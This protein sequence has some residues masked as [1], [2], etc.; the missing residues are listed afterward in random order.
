VDSSIEVGMDIAA[1]EPVNILMVDDQPAKL[2][3]YEAILRDLGE[4]LVKASSGREALEHLLKQDFAMI[5]VDVCMPEQDGFALVELIRQHPRF[6]KIPVIFISAVHLSDMDRNKGYASGAV[7]YVSVPVVPVVL[8]TKVAVFADL[9]RKTRDLARLN[10]ELESRVLMRT[11]ELHKT[12][13]ALLEM[14]RRKDEFLATL[15]HELR[16]P[17]A[18]MQNSVEL[19]RRVKAGDSAVEPIVGT[20]D[21]QLQQLAHLISDLMDVSRITR[22]KLELKREPVLL[23]TIIAN[24]TEM[25]RPKLAIYGHEFTVGDLVEDVLVDADPIRL[26]QV[27]FNLLS[28]AI[29]YTP[30]PGRIR[31]EAKVTDDSAEICVADN[32]TGIDTEDQTRIFEPFYQVDRTLERAQGGLGIGLTLVKTIVEKHGGTI[33]VQ[34]NGNGT[35]STFVIRIPRVQRNEPTATLE[36]PTANPEAKSLR[37]LVVDD[38]QDAAETLTRLLLHLGHEVETCYDGNAACEKAAVYEPDAIFMDIGM[39]VMNGYDAARQIRSQP[40]GKDTILIALTGWGQ[41]EDRRK[42]EAAGFDR[43]IVKPVTLSQLETILADLNPT[44]PSAI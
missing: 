25:A 22:N 27:V 1:S 17:L 26:T 12:Q 34:S 38:N 11:E 19:L 14:D 4:N 40:G 31:L 41:N 28:N 2:L 37:L 44:A 39:P 42:T 32:G 30:K 9:Y 36:G 21:R 15:A 13:N 5:L 23:S 20:L 7:D 43:H 35:G 18:P 10:H 33:D 24:A 3:S 6:Q 16:N 8:R 29:K